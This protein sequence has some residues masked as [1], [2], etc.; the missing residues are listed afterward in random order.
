MSQA[1]RSVAYRQHRLGPKPI[2]VLDTIGSLAS[3][4]YLDSNTK[5]Y[6]EIEQ[7]SKNFTLSPFD[8]RVKP[9]TKNTATATAHF[10]SLEFPYSHCPSKRGD[11]FATAPEF[12]GFG[13]KAVTAF[14]YVA[15][16]ATHLDC[17][18]GDPTATDFI[19]PNGIL[20]PGPSVI[21]IRSVK[22]G[23]SKT[24]MLVETREPNYTSWYDGSV[25]WVVAADPNGPKPTMGSYGMLTLAPKSST[26]LN[27]GPSSANFNRF[28]IPMAKHSNIVSNWQWGPSSVH[29]G[30]VIIH[31]I[32][33]GSVRSLADD[34]DPVLYLHLVTREG[35]EPMSTPE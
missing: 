19:E 28:Y 21:T 17:M 14:N 35:R 29:A 5:L 26:A 2:P 23:T 25:G 16:S 4:P 10:V 1:H 8:P 13:P 11:W 15:L 20:V 27:I 6:E 34:I 12:V 32:A 18:L 9:S 24:L 22:D 3:S 33:D 31:G 7:T 30:D